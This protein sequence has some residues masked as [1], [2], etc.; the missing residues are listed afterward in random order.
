[1]TCKN[2]KCKGGIIYTYCCSGAMCECMGQPTE[3]ECPVC[4]KQHSSLSE[5]TSDGGKVP[6][7]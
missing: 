5:V 1:M 7:E 3:E 6:T 2:K 4:S